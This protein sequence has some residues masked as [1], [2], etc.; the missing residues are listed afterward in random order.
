MT[1]FLESQTIL[2]KINEAAISTIPAF[3]RLKPGGHNLSPALRL[4]SGFEA[5]LNDLR[6]GKYFNDKGLNTFSS[7]K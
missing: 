3:K 7:S 2:K 1:S 4:C 6:G 5:N